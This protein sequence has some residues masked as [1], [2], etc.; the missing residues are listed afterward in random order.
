M[1]ELAPVM[2]MIFAAMVAGSIT[3]LHGFGKLVGFEVTNAHSSRRAT[4][5]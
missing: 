4:D 1:P 3:E 5:Q 2:R